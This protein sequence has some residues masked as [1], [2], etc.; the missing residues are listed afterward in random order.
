MMAVR[1]GSWRFV[2]PD[3]LAGRTIDSG[4]APGLQVTA[5]RADTVQG[6]DSIHQAILLLL[7]TRPG[8]RV[9]RPEYGCDLGQFVFAPIDDTTAGL[10]I[11]YVSRAIE[12]WEP[13]IKVLALDATP[14]PDDPTKLDLLVEY[15]VHAT[16]QDG[17]VAMS[18]AGGAG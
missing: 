8:E 11:H 2:H 3:L 7:S 15:R 18:V 17:Q 6:D 10:A 4:Q 13:R 14:N 5:G 1:Y 9:M 16:G 12:R